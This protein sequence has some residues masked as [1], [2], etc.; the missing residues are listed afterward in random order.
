MDVLVLDESFTA[1]GILDSYK[2]LIWTDRFAEYGDFEI[3][4]AMDTDLETLLQKDR[5]L[6]MNDSEHVMMIESVKITTDAEDGN[7]LTVTGKSL[8]AILGRRIIWNQK[9]F[10]GSLQDA[11]QTMLNE[12]II[13]PSIADR[14]IPN[15]IK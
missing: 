8:E 6:W 13:S 9:E 12:A 7:F 14:K 10:K 11:I 5:Y 15:F 4:A 3:Y 1:I 2:S